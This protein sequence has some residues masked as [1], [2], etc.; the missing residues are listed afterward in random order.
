MARQSRASWSRFVRKKASAKSYA[1]KRRTSQA[2][3]A[4]G[5]GQ[6][7]VLDGAIYWRLPE[8]VK[9]L[10]VIKTGLARHRDTQMWEQLLTRAI[11]ASDDGTAPAHPATVR[12][13]LDIQRVVPQ[14]RFMLD[15][16]N[17]A[18]A[19]GL[20]D[21]VKRLG[22]IHDDCMDWCDL[23]MSQ[24]VATDKCYWTIVKVSPATG[25]AVIADHLWPLETT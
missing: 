11:L 8:R 9:S 23:H 7:L 19:K 10:N 22:Y 3:R 5:V 14:K 25:P 6:K 16:L 18:G 1:A 12:M 15:V 4:T 2:H 24:R 17:L 21:A 20:E 13:R